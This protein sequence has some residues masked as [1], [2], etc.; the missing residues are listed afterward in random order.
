M[1]LQAIEQ[2]IQ[3]IPGNG[4]VLEE[5][6]KLI[7]SGEAIALVGAGASAGLWPLW[8]ELLKGFVEFSQKHG[9]INS[10]EA[11]IFLQ[12]AP[13]TPLETAQQLRNTIGERDY[14]EY[15]QN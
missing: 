5:L 8:N 6:Y 7:E 3:F 10:V 1:N 15:L 11:D 9:K 12:Q 2:E 4:P 13:H 14:F